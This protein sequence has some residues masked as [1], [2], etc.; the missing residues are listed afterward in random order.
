MRHDVPM[1]TG[2]P[3]AEIDPS[4]L[5]R[6]DAVV[7]CVR[8]WRLRP[9]STILPVTGHERVVPV[10]VA[11]WGTVLSDSAVIASYRRVVD[12]VAALSGVR[13]LAAGEVGGR[14]FGLLD[15]IVAAYE[16]FRTAVVEVGRFDPP[17]ELVAN[18]DQ[19]GALEH[20]M[21]SL[22]SAAITRAAEGLDDSC[23]PDLLSQAARCRDL[24]AELFAEQPQVGAADLPFERALG[25]STA[26]LKAGD[27]MS[28]SSRVT[29]VWSRQGEV[30]D[31]RLRDRLPHLV[32][33]QVEL[34]NKVRV[35][36]TALF[37]CVHPLPTHAAAVAG[38]DLVR[39]SLAEDPARCLAA[40]A[41]QVRDE[42][43]MLFTHRRVIAEGIAWNAA[44]HA[45]DR[46]GP[47]LDMYLN[48]MEGDV[49]RTAR[50]VLRLLGRDAGPE[51]TLG[52][53]VQQLTREADEPMCSLL[54]AHVDRDWRNAIA[55]SQVH[56]DA[57]S[58][59][60]MLGT[61]AVDPVVVAE[62]ARRVHD[63]CAGFE[64]GVAVALNDAGNPHYGGSVELGFVGWDV[65]VMRRLGSVGVNA[66]G[67]RRD[68][69][70]IWLRVPPL[71]MAS[72]WDLVVGVFLAGRGV[73]DLDGW[74]IAQD[75]RPDLVLADKTLAAVERLT[76][77]LA[78]GQ[79]ALHP[80]A[81]G[82]V[83]C[84][85]ALV[86]HGADVDAVVRTVVALAS[87]TLVAE[88]D[89]DGAAVADLT[90][91]LEAV[92]PAVHRSADLVDAAGRRALAAFATMLTNLGADLDTCLSQVD[93]AMRS[94]TPIDLPWLTPVE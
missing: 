80:D 1:V 22:V 61:T 28:F 55:H 51:L 76:T 3:A 56:W 14:L 67:F 63:L 35:H 89:R 25:L 20:A 57:V 50:L 7:K 49:R 82:I 5:A 81:A 60:A 6:R 26:D 75:G 65:E 41:D 29:A 38:R 85:G 68:G 83:L 2:D 74:R 18:V 42:A 10:S 52:P 15:A 54:V 17:A 87:V 91:T 90:A 8:G 40:I 59:K 73:P 66:T 64:T 19:L 4:V 72:L 79:A 34:T 45:E 53:L 86:S 47:A 36:L 13:G 94:T 11:Q 24:V 77:P 43:E 31:S 93:L 32:D 58:Q 27:G 39:R 46:M 44:E 23:W 62:A 71:T 30:L 69:A 92:I 21:H 37:G 70:V 48:V 16:Q 84:A 33:P 9:G 78:D 88:R 12:R